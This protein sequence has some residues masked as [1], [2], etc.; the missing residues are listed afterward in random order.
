VK[1][2]PILFSAPM[3][4]AILD[5]RKSQTRRVLKPQPRE[6]HWFGLPGYEHRLLPSAT[7]DGFAARSV[8]S[9]QIPGRERAVDLGEWISCPYGAPGDRLWVRETFSLGLGAQNHQDPKRIVYRATDNRPAYLWKPS[10]L[11]P[12]WASRLTLEVT[13]VRDERLNAITWADARTEGVV[14]ASGAWE[15]DGP[16]LDTDRAG[17]RGAFESLWESINGADSWAANPWVW[18][19]EFKRVTNH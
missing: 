1:E 5:G 19:V 15:A 8:H 13:D 10:I 2:R 3:V 4:R 6:H 16:L 17:P 14:D 7:G 18:V 12:R 9:H 11:M